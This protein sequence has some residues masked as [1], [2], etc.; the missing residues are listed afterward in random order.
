MLV[1]TEIGDDTN[2]FFNLNQEEYII[3]FDI[4]V[5]DKQALTHHSELVAI[6]SSQRT[7]ELSADL[8]G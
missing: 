6:L 7:H 8:L 4:H 2:L 1:I 3:L 5:K